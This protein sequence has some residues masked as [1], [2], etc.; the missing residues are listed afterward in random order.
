[1]VGASRDGGQG[2]CGRQLST[3]DPAVLTCGDGATLSYDGEDVE[4]GCAQGCSQWEPARYLPALPLPIPVPDS[5]P[6][7][8]PLL[9][10]VFP[11][12]GR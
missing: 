6:P 3:H 11:N 2:L 5:A 12:P 9:I 10:P 8:L 7:S 4:V 1:M